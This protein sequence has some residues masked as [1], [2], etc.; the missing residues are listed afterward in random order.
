MDNVVS[1]ATLLALR[2]IAEGRS[3]GRGQTD[4]AYLLFRRGSP[5]P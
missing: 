4:A 3:G 2:E 1:E 5:E